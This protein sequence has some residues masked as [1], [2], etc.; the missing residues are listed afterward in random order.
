MS[1]SAMTEKPDPWRVPIAVLQIPDTGLHRD[2][3]AGEATRHA[4]ADI[5][6]LREVLSAHASFDVTPKSGGR[7]H[8]TGQVRARI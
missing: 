3:E 6:G 1:K 4:V 7:Y 2:L 8:V 5:G